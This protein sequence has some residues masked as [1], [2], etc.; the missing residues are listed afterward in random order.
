MASW[1]RCT[2][3]SDSRRCRQMKR[4]KS[5][6]QMNHL[7]SYGWDAVLSCSVM[8][9]ACCRDWS[10]CIAFGHPATQLRGMCQLLPSPKQSGYCQPNHAAAA[11][12]AAQMSP[13]SAVR[14]SRPSL[15]SMPLAMACSSEVAR[16]SSR[17]CG[18]TCLRPRLSSVSCEP[19]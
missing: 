2:K 4:A 15:L 8:S 16:C 3:L 18:G 13:S 1:C 9:T 19:E 11:A 17:G 14:P 5:L 6:Q 10:A 7:F 12:A